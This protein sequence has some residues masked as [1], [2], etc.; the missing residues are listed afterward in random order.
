M[1]DGMLR[2]VYSPGTNPIP[3]SPLCF[4]T[5]GTSGTSRDESPIFECSIESGEDGKMIKKTVLSLPDRDF[6]GTPYVPVYV[7]LPV[8]P[9]SFLNH[10]YS[11]HYFSY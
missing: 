2:G 10:G 9:S 6:S 5:A 4:A 8:I 7:M 3:A 1:V 11:F